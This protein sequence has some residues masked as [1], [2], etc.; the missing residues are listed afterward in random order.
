MNRED[1]LNKTTDLAKRLGLEMRIVEDP[2]TSLRVVVTEDHLPP[3]Q[4]V[5]LKP[6]TS[7]LLVV[8]QVSL[9]EDDYKRLVEMKY[10]DVDKIFW[11][12]RLRLLSM[13]VDFKAM[14]PEK[15]PTNWEVSSKLFIEETTAQDFFEIYTKIKNSVFCIVWSIRHALDYV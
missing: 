2:A 14:K 9:S 7:Y 15:I 5:L 1:I 12:L 3:I 10:K 13:G 11:E 6:E 8:S 4:L